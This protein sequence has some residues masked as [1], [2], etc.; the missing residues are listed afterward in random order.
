M[1]FSQEIRFKI[2]GDMSSLK[3]SFADVESTAERAGRKLEAAIAKRIPKGAQPGS[4]QAAFWGPT[5]AEL[6]RLERYKKIAEAERAARA[7]AAARGARTRGSDYNEGDK[8]DAP[9]RLS[10]STVFRGIGS[11]IAAALRGAIGYQRAGIQIAGAQESSTSSALASTQARFAAIG[12]LQGQLDQGKR[13]SKNLQG[14]KQFYEDRKKFLSTGVLAKGVDFLTKMGLG[15]DELTK[16]EIKL[17]EINADIQK[18]GDSNDL[19]Q[20]ELNRQTETYENQIDAIQQINRLQLNG[21]ANAKAIAAVELRAA[22]FQLGT[23][24]AHGTPQ[25]QQ[26]AKIAVT[27]A[28]GKL[29]AARVQALARVYDVNSELTG[30]VREGRTFRNGR[31]KPL[32]ETE[33]IAQRAAQYQERARQMAIAGGRSQLSKDTVT[34][35]G[36]YTGKVR[37]DE[38]AV[39]DRLNQAT[40][41][42]TQTPTVDASSI[43]VQLT[44]ANQLLNGIYGALRETDI[45]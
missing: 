13:S 41:G 40:T 37:R 22:K 42:A 44:K 2:G 38:Q 31:Q 28:E 36:F 6:A 29:N 20:R 30:Q 45:K 7:K 16:V 9:R 33:R 24:Q 15:T 12:G 32:S 39:A 5:P 43:G 8:E 35:I 34:G 10:A 1:G 11:I 4:A 18:Q 23:E 14:D 26:A 27:Q 21:A 17:Q 3:K 25:S 19:V